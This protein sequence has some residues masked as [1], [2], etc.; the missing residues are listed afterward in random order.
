VTSI[1]SSFLNPNFDE[2]KRFAELYAKYSETF[3]CV[4]PGLT[5]AVLEGLANH[6]EEWGE[7]LCPCRHYEDKAAEVT[8]NYWVCP[9]VPMQERHQCECMLFLQAESEFASNRQEL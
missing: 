2:M 7:A 3:F 4:D 6:K 5:T 9:C 8:A 1:A